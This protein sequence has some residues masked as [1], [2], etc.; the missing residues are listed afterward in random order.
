MPKRN[1]LSNKQIL[2]VIWKSAKKRIISEIILV[3]LHI[4]IWFFRGISEEIFFGSIA[5]YIFVVQQ[6]D[7]V[8]MLSSSL[9][10]TFGIVLLVIAISIGIWIWVDI[11]NRAKRKEVGRK[12]IPIVNGIRRCYGEYESEL[13][14]LTKEAMHY[15][16]DEYRTNYLLNNT[17]YQELLSQGIVE[18]DATIEIL[19]KLSVNPHLETLM[20][21]ERITDLRREISRLII[22]LQQ[23]RQKQEIRKVIGELPK[24]IDNHLDYLVMDESRK[25]YNELHL[26][27]YSSIS[28]K[29]RSNHY[30][31]DMQIRNSRNAAR[32]YILNL[33]SIIEDYYRGK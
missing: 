11:K 24:A 25:I 7:K 10:L 31:Y 30:Q 17:E 5:Q 18:S 6:M 9:R 13:E 12:L 19:G 29:S 3:P 2:R 33:L 28:T 27:H 15:L 32:A 21:N 14:R 26:K 8:A 20:D 4:F 22:S 16:L 1:K 23:L